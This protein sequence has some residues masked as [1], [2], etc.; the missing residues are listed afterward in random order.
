MAAGAALLPIIIGEWQ[1]IAA[2]AT[3]VS[4]LKVGR[5][6]PFNAGWRF[7]RGAG[8]GL[9]ASTLDDSALATHRSAARLEHRGCA[10]RA[11]A[12]PARPVHKASVGGDRTGFTGRRRLVPQAFPPR[13]TARHARVEVLFDGVYLESDVWLN[14]QPLGGN[15]NGYIPFA[16]DLTPHLEPRSA[17]TCWRSA[18]ATSGSNTRWY[19]GSGIYREVRIDVLPAGARTRPLGR[20]CLDPADC[21]R[22]TRDRRHAPGSRR[23]DPALSS[24]D[25]TARCSRHGRCGSDRRLRRAKL[26]QSLSVRAPRLWSPASPELYTLETELRCGGAV[27]DRLVQ[28]FG[29]RIVTFDPKRGMAINGD[30]HDPTRRLR[31]SR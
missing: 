16:F 6:Q 10:G 26:R 24:V 21:R 25:P 18:C 14:G 8:E 11:R 28:P 23:R 15:V 5:D 22:Q 20:R 17:T 27:I 1:A 3:V 4:A 7:L 30:Q 31:S 9:E 13:R 19:S 2:P 12:R 29:I